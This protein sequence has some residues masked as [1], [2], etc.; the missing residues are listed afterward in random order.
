[1]A[2]PEKPTADK[3]QLQDK[4]NALAEEITADLSHLEVI[5][6][7]EVLSD[8]VSELFLRMAK[9]DQKETRQQKQADGIAA[10]KARG[11]QFGPS[12]KPLPENFD[13]CYQAWRN[14][15][16]SKSQA[17][18]SCGMTRVAF[19]RAVERMEEDCSA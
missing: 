12:R 8:F 4:L 18:Q 3:K 9:Q 7:K 16:M 19:W 2:L 10:A 6:R 17:A 1:M 14:G 5:Q 15:Q 11:V 13:R